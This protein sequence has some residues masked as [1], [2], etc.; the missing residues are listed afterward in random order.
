MFYVKRTKIV[1][2]DLYLFI[3]YEF[4]G[5]WIMGDGTKAGNA[6]YLQTQ[7]FTVEECVFIISVLKYKFNLNCN[8][9][10]QRKQPTIYI[11]KSNK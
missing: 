9:H 8:I 1:P 5:Y 3:D 4:L 11:A 6:I 10:M 7:S 2:L